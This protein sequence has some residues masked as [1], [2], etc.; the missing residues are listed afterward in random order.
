[1]PEGERPTCTE[2]TKSTE[3]SKS[4]EETKAAKPVKSRTAKSR[5]VPS[6]LRR[7]DLLLQ[8]R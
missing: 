1:V 2:E 4:A 6:W 3:E 7:V 5:R 8:G